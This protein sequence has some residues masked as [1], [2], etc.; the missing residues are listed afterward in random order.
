MNPKPSASTA[1][2]TAGAFIATAGIAFNLPHA[3]DHFAVNGVTGDIVTKLMLWL[4]A[5]VPGIAAKIW[6]ALKARGIDVGPVENINA[7]LLLALAAILKSEPVKEI[8]V[9]VE[10]EPKPFVFQIPKRKP[11][12]PPVKAVEAAT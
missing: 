10:G 8:A 4:A 11:T 5:T 3:Q 9:T 1:L 6:E 7:G 12:P 2:L